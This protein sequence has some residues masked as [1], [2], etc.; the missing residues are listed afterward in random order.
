M[1]DLIHKSEP[2]G[3]PDGMPTC[4]SLTISI[5]IVVISIF[6]IIPLSAGDWD[7]LRF[8]MIALSPMEGSTLLSII[9]YVLGETR[10]K[11]YLLNLAIA[12]FFTIALWAKE[13]SQVAS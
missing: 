9:L 5:Q 8:W 1:N 12:A 11:A 6:L 7:R 10:C 2:Q 4:V 3:P 13:L